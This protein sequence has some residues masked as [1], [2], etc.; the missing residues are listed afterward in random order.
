M[1]GLNTYRNAQLANNQLWLDKMQVIEKAPSWDHWLSYRT[2][3]RPRYPVFFT[4]ALQRQMQEVLSYCDGKFIEIQ[5]ESHRTEGEKKPHSRLGMRGLVHLMVYWQNKLFWDPDTDRAQMLQEYYRLFFGPAEQE[6]R[7]FYEFAEEVWSRQESR[8]LTE[9]TG[10]LKEADV[11]RFFALL[12]AAREKA[13]A[14]TVYDRRVEQ[15]ES[16]MVSIKKLFP[17]LKRIGPSIRLYSAPDKVAI[18]GDLSEYK[19]GWATL[20]DNTTGETPKKNRTS[21]VLAMMPNNAGIIIGAVCY[22]NRMDSL[23]A[24]C[25]KDDDFS[26]FQ[27]DVIE[28]YLNSPERS[29]FKIVVNPNA[30]VWDETTDVAIIDR[31][32]LPVLW[33]PGVKAVV[34]KLPDRWIVEILIPTQDL[35]KLGPTADY[36]WGIE[37]GRTRFTGGVV[38][39]WALAPTSGAY[40]TPNRWANLWMR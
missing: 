23:K 27:D 11:D 24:D 17:N 3:A 35:G 16:E 15:I 33:N 7:T 13:G 38:G 22:E 5:P 37:V 4:R 8:S 31:D 32:T 1:W 14:G 9:S 20:R 29:Y 12:T 2:T 21:V 18:D 36:P 39:A 6:M 10:F 25:S 19:Y 28:I 30:A 34:K 40:A 26:I